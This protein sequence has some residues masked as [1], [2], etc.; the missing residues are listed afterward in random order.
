MYF[1]YVLQSQ[2]TGKHYTGHTSNLEERLKSHNSGNSP[3]TK[4]RGPWKLLYFENYETRSEAMKRE[5][6]FKTGAGRNFLMKIL[7]SD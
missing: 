2:T 7:S 6:F 3:Y 4:G 1:T 5:S